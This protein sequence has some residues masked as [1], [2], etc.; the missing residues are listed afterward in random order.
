MER[1][2]RRRDFVAAARGMRLQRRA[3]A[4]EMR[5]RDDKGPGRFG[6]TVTKRTAAKAV[7]RNRIRRRLR[8]AVR[9][10]A[11]DAVPSGFDHVLV[12]RRGAL[13]LDFGELAAD[14]RSAIAQGCR[15]QCGRD[16]ERDAR[17]SR[18]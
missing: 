5:R 3:F 4:L 15:G 18:T 9:L 13:T 12:G 7:E 11:P 10:L 8:E 14:L 17:S 16:E 2:K 6:F 1:L